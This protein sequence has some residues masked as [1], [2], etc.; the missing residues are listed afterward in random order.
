MQGENMSKMANYGLTFLVAL[1]LGIG[2]SR[3]VKLLDSRNASLENQVQQTST[4]TPQ[5]NGIEAQ[6]PG[7]YVLPLEQPVAYDYNVT[8]RIA[9]YTKQHPDIGVLP[10][11]GNGSL[12]GFGVYARQNGGGYTGMN[13]DIVE[14]AK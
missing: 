14:L 11:V 1:A 5:S 9:D 8:G 4:A 6:L 13:C 12:T 7:L 2:V 10:I 3:G